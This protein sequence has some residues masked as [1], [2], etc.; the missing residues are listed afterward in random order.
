MEDKRIIDLS[1]EE[2]NSLVEGVVSAF[3]EVFELIF[4]AVD[5]SIS[6]QADFERLIRSNT[7]Q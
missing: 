4:Q 1:E 2:Y 5:D 7:Q 6:A 3:G